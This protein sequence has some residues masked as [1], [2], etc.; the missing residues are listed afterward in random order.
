ME[1]TDDG[2]VTSSLTREQVRISLLWR[3]LTFRDQR[4]ARIYDQHEDDLDIGTAVE[5]F[6]AGP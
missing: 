2:S 4:A 3:A 6:C 1:I 5:M